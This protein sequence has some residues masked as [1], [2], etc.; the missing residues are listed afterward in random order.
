MTTRA[1][2]LAASGLETRQ[3]VP[4]VPSEVALDPPW[5]LLPRAVRW[6]ALPEVRTRHGR[7]EGQNGAGGPGLPG[8]VS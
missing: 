3:R 7:A 2:G 6:D 4:T 1:Q 8:E 5:L